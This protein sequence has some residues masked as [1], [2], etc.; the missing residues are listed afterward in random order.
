[1]PIRSIFW[2]GTSR[3]D[4]HLLRGHAVDN[5]WNDRLFFDTAAATSSA[6]TY[7][8]DHQPPDVTL[9]FQPLFKGDPSPAQNPP[10]P[11]PAHNVFSGQGITVDMLTGRITVAAFAPP[12]P[13]NNFIIEVTATNNAGGDPMR[14]AIRVHLHTSVTTVA[15]TPGTLTV[16]PSSA[17]RTA[18]ERTGYWFTV[19]A[20]FDDDTM[21]DLT[22]HHGVTWSSVPADHVDFDGELI[23]A[24]GDVAG[25]API[26]ITATL[27]AELGGGSA[28]ATL[29]IGRPWRDDPALPEASIVVGG[30]WPGTTLP[31]AAPNVMF[32]GDGFQDAESTAFEQIATTMVHHLKTDRLLRP[33]DLLCTSMNFWRA[34]VP[35]ADRGIS[36]RCEVFIEQTGT[37]VAWPVPPP[38]RPLASGDFNL[39][40]L[41]YLVG[42]PVPTD[43]NKSI[44]DLRSDWDALVGPQPVPH[45]RIKDDII[46][47][48][49]LLAPRG[50]IEELDN[51]PA[52]SFG[53][54]PVARSL[55]G[56]PLLGLHDLRGGRS[57]LS[58]LF[59]SMQSESNV[60]VGGGR[61]GVLWA[62]RPLR[63]DDTVYVLGDVVTVTTAPALNAARLFAC[64]TPGRS[65]AAEP[66]EYGTAADGT[67]IQDGGA[68]FRAIR[69]A[70]NNNPLLVVV[71]SFP[72]G[73]AVNYGQNNHI[74]IST[75]SGTHPIPVQAR[76]MGFVLDLDETDVP[77]DVDIDTCRTIAHEIGHS[78]GL[79]DEYIERP[80][81]NFP[82]TEDDLAHDLNLQTEI[83]TQVNGQIDALRLR[84]NWH[85]IRKAAVISAAITP[86]AAGAY[87][88]PVVPGQAWQFHK[89][90]TVLLR[91]RLPGEFLGAAYVVN[92]QVSPALE[93]AVA[94]TAAAAN[95][96][97]LVQAAAGAN[98]TDATMAAFL[99]GSIVFLPVP[100]P[101]AVRTAAY[102]YAEIIA[103]NIRDLIGRRHQPLY[104][105]PTGD[106]LQKEL[107]N[108]RE[109]QEPKVDGLAPQLPGRPFCFKDKPR[110]VGLYE[111]GSLSTRGIF[112]PTGTCM[113]RNDHLDTGEF[114]AVCRY[115]M[116]EF[117][118]P[119]HHFQIDRDYDDIYPLT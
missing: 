43:A 78:F 21:G 93:I 109:L 35:A 47:S 88:I 62:G 111:G 66:A 10:P 70:F 86:V 48:W 108:E 57:A 106:D 59:G 55:T 25:G 96:F 95:D 6:E 92:S 110:I 34:F 49:K 76:P 85:R 112:H 64:T 60:Q 73:R 28:T 58:R 67:T 117:I 30:G 40:H 89:D 32:L 4:I 71:S 45:G 75:R 61:I 79:G 118:N 12:L 63:R 98:V 3:Q 83:D 11:Q 84:W 50:F 24:P 8:N 18:P 69:V 77:T 1:M 87:K 100:A 5:L 113:M 54:P 26:T 39:G 99:P 44:A 17:T 16:R 42:L 37:T 38:E 56:T 114:C 116:V 107:D 65:A 29:Q 91:H 23:I 90:D 115:I 19:R 20:L 52:M 22:E 105:Q 82:G 94:P 46:E 104:R 31:E 72:A 53:R 74:A 51:F 27:P 33:F 14:E 41:I 9:T 119:F 13:K 80:D 7:F 2:T 81:R 68:A 15:L 97:L 36:F 101:S 102:P 103:K